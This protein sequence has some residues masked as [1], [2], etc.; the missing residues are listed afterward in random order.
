MTLGRKLARVLIGTA[1]AGSLATMNAA[2]ALA[3]AVVPEAEEPGVMTME[4]PKPS[5]FFVRGG[6][7]SAGTSI[8]DAGTGKMI[9]MVATSRDSDLGID[10]SGKF[11]Y[12]AETMWSKVNRGTRQDLVSVYDSK[13]LKL[14]GEI[15]TP[16][17]LIVGGFTT[18]FVLTD[19]GKT[20]YDY[21]FDPASSV[22]IIDL[23]KRK[24]VRAIEL[25]GCAGMIPN[26]G[27]GFSS[28]CADGTIATVA[29]KGATQDITRTE[30]FFDAAADPIWSNTVYDRK[31]KQVVMLS[32]TGVVR[33]AAVG[34]KVE[35]G[36]PFSIQEA[37]GMKAADVKPLDIAWYPGGMQ[38]MALHRPTG[39]LWVLMHKG[40]YWSHKEG[41]E[42]IWGIDLAAKKVVKRYPV[43]DEPSNIQ[44]TQD[45]AA[46]IMVNGGGKDAVII[47]SKTGEVKHK[48][49]NGGSGLITVVESM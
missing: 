10:P 17:R 11:Y 16:G 31:K 29:I 28:L 12:V 42:E 32:Y 2:V 8:F 1:I 34:A 30:P 14:L 48:I 36:A 45:D 18:N 21:N 27:V 35:V 47:D 33:T 9:G 7:G 41:A 13:T 6:W 22:N 23:T 20:A 43:E 44:I 4:A 3:E 5:W 39:M 26:P 24:F 38:P 46:M 15:P 49:E 19:D 40:E 25:P 37:G